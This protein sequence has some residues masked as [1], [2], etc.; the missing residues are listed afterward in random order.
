MQDRDPGPAALAGHGAPAAALGARG[1]GDV[2]G[3]PGAIETVVL[4]GKAIGQ[5]VQARVAADAAALRAQGVVPSLA[6]LRVGDD[7]ASAIYVRAKLR[8]AAALGIVAVEH[9]LPA[10]ASQDAVE[11]RVG[12]LCGDHD[13]DGVLVQLPLPAHLDSDRV[14]A[15]VDADKDVDGL[16]IENLGL[17]AIGAPGLRPCTPAGVMVLLQ[18]WSAQSGWTLRGKRA[19][20]IGRS[21]IVGKPMA[22]LLLAADATVTIAHSRSVDLAAEVARADLVVAAAG[23]PQLVQG[24]WLKPGAVVI[25]V[26]IHRGSDGKLLGDVD[27]ASTLGRAA[28]VTP[29]PGGVGPMTIAMLMSNTV[30]AARSRRSLHA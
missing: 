17:L 29:V 8:T 24:A 15:L 5:A 30:Q 13:I 12:A 19:L 7:P 28:A 18:A 22:Q 10:H 14:L 6:V 9:T 11:A 3:A 21:R 26:G 27:T 23:V 1:A 2:T 4:D 20:V 16:G 25:D